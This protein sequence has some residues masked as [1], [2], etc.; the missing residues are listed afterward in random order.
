MTRL[1]KIIPRLCCEH[2]A[3]L[4]SVMSPVASEV[5]TFIFYPSDVIGGMM[6]LA[7][8]LSCRMGGAFG[9]LN[10]FERCVPVRRMEGLSCSHYCIA[11]WG[12]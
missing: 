7:S 3:E 2:Y 8:D 5:K 4:L 1:F 10:W 11:L 6:D 9:G 12:M